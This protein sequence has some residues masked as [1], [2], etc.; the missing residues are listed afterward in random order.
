MNQPPTRCPRAATVPKWAASAGFALAVTAGTVVTGPAGAITIRDDG[1]YATYDAALATG[2]IASNVGRLTTNTSGSGTY[3]GEGWVL[4]AAHLFG[5]GI[6]PIDTKYF[7]DGVQYNV[8]Q[9]AV[10]PEWTG[11]FAEGH[12]FALVRLTS[13]IAGLGGVPFYGGTVQDL[14]GETLTYSGFGFEGNGSDGGDFP[15][16]TLHTA[17]NRVDARGQSVPFFEE[18]NNGVAY[19]EQVF[20]ADFDDPTES[21]DGYAWSPNNTLT[22]EGLIAGGDSGGGVFLDDNGT[23]RLVGANS[24]L[25]GTDGA[26]NGSYSDIAGAGGLDGVL[27]WIADVTGTAVLL[28]G[29]A[30]FSG[31]V[32]QGDL[33]AVLQNWGD[34]SN[35]GWTLGDLD[36]SG[37]IEQGDLDLVLAGWGSALAPSFGNF[38]ISAVPEPAAAAVLTLAAGLLRRRR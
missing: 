17:Q 4:T 20:F 15:L 2:V 33:D 7:L 18:D 35:V 10:H 27:P 1:A 23:L 21:N 8:A 5:P 16:G 36:G 31:Q 14:L 38:A 24:F 13:P 12:D 19:D 3:L 25:L 6:N 30:N 32:E 11:Q 9:I 37:Q 34:S 22:F 29:D 28:P 26:A